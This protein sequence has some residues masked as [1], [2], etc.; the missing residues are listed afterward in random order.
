MIDEFISYRCNDCGNCTDI[1]CV[2]DPMP[3]GWIS[4]GRQTHYCPE[5]AK[6]HSSD[7]NWI[8]V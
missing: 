6:K 3:K 4:N 1:L 8:E 5:C 2:D 7:K